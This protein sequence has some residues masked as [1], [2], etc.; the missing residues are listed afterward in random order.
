MW[1]RR[2]LAALRRPTWMLATASLRPSVSASTALGQPAETNHFRGA[3]HRV[4]ACR[5]KARYGLGRLSTLI[6]T[7]VLPLPTKPSRSAAA[8]E[9]ST[10][11]PVTWGPRSFTR[12]TKDLLFLRLVTSILEPRG[13]VRCAAVSSVWLNTSPLAVTPPDS[14]PY[15]LAT[16]SSLGSELMG[17]SVNLGATRGKADHAS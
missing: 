3:I 1:P 8:L 2:I 15:Q 4:G 16:P 5:S 14:S 13:K 6:C 10:K 17:S 12:K 11:S 7:A 9:T